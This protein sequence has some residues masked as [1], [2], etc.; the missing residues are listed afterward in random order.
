MALAETE[1]T[2]ADHRPDWGGSTANHAEAQSSLSISLSLNVADQVLSLPVCLVS[3]AGWISL[4]VSVSPSKGGGADFI[5]GKIQN[6]RGL[7]DLYNLAG[8]QNKHRIFG[9]CQ[10]KTKIALCS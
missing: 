3:L 5:N 4:C 8:Y 10:N 7:P 1:P 2:K 6:V 9:V